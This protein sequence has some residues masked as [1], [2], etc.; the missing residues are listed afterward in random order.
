MPGG[1]AD[2]LE[3]ALRWNQ[4]IKCCATITIQSV[5]LRSSTPGG[6][7]RTCAHA[8]TRT[9]AWGPVAVLRPA[10]P[11]GLDPTACPPRPG[12]LLHFYAA[13]ATFPPTQQ[14][15]VRARP[16]H[17]HTHVLACPV[18][19]ATLLLLAR[20]YTAYIFGTH[21]HTRVRACA[22]PAQSHGYVS[23]KD[24]AVWQQVK[25]NLA[26]LHTKL[27]KT[28]RPCTPRPRRSYTATR[29]VAR[30]TASSCRPRTALG[31]HPLCRPPPTHSVAPRPT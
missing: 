17:V 18:H 29:H 25:Q 22:Y 10:P 6:A 5:C 20:M 27:S 30:C 9:C 1:S 31:Q 19:A 13:G 15:K 26:A 8:H 11:R 14:T 16:G 12:L 24:Y 21:D 4:S 2:E 3:N 7:V 28:W 23:I